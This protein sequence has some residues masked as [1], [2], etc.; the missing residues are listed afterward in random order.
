MLSDAISGKAAALWSLRG[1]KLGGMTGFTASSILNFIKNLGPGNKGLHLSVLYVNLGTYELFDSEMM[2]PTYELDIPKMEQ[3][4]IQE[5]I[6]KMVRGTF[7]LTQ[8]D[9]WHG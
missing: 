7:K 5:R 8:G 4:L 2:D 6:G 9:Y 3:I 1:L